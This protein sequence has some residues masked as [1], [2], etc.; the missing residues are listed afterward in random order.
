[1]QGRD[2]DPDIEIRPADT[3]EEGEGETDESSIHLANI[4]SFPKMSGPLPLQAESIP[5]RIFLQN[6]P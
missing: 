5:S 2:R 3:A 1:M 6:L 4:S